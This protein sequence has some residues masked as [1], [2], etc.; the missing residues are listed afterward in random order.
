M[1]KKPQKYNT[2]NIY[3]C[4]NMG[5]YILYLFIMILWKEDQTSVKYATAFLNSLIFA[6]P[7]TIYYEVEEFT[8]KCCMV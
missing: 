1:Q 4:E 7:K 2:E 5:D 3:F 8:E 6:L